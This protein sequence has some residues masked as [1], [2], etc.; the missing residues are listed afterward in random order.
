MKMI[1]K[2]LE[3]KEAYFYFAF[4]VLIGVLFFQHGGQK[5]FGLFGGKSQ[6]L[7]S[8]MGLAG[9]IEFFG[10]IAIALGLFTR[11]VALITGIEMVSAYLMVHLPHGWIPIVNKGELALLYLSGFLVLIAYGAKKWSLERALFKKECF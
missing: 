6:A 7:F 10:G 1:G 9:I 11:L 8:L 3:G 5:L 2:Y 4:R